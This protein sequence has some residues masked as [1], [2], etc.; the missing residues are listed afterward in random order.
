MNNQNM[1]KVALAINHIAMAVDD[2][3]LDK[4]KNYLND[5]EQIILADNRGEI[6]GVDNGN[7]KV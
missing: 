6:Y 1:M 5:I 3:T 7:S 2:A 4:I